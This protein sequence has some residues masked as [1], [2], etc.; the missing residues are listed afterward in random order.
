MRQAKI[1]P[2]SNDLDPMYASLQHTA[3]FVWDNLVE[4]V[5]ISLAWFLAALPLVTIGPATVGAYRAVLS[6]RE[7]EA[8]GIDRSA[9]L[10]TVREGFVHATLLSFVP[11]VLLVSA[12]N[13]VLAY[14]ASGAVTAG[15]LGLGCLY[16]GL[17]AALVSMPTLLGLAAG[18]PV[19][20]AF[21]DGY[22][23]T[24]RHAV[25]AVAL[26]VVT[27]VLFVVSSL[28]TVAVAVLFAG[29]AFALHVEFVANVSAP[30]EATPVATEVTDA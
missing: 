15:L 1:K 8:D 18:K 21:A 29:V 2:Q 25:G 4:V 26:G 16:A 14:L 7:G 24:A 27:V 30:A 23:W 28:L 3:R 5:W 13:Y 10:E 12:A 22:R 9:V 19:L 17:Y 6:L 11:L 20:E